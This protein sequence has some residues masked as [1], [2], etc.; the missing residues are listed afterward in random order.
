[1]TKMPE[2]YARD[3]PKFHYDRP[4][5]LNRF[6]KRVEELFKTHKIEDDREKIRYLGSYA[7]PKTENEWEGMMKYADGTFTEFKKEII[8][9]YPEASNQTRGSI[10]ELKR[11]RDMYSG[12]SPA[13]ITRLAVFKR[14]FIAE[15]KKLQKD[16]AL[17]SNHESVEYFIPCQNHPALVIIYRLSTSSFLQQLL[18]RRNVFYIKIFNMAT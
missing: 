13:D 14:A 8:E 17:L 6:I 4:E 9:S 15:V 3:A 12:I 1:M 16:P 5:E 2:P 18:V 10:K 11:I 7:D